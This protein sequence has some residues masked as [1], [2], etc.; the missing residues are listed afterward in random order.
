M[1]V[2]IALLS[3]SYCHSKR[4]ID[5]RKY[6]M[7]PDEYGGYYFAPLLSMAVRI[8]S[9]QDGGSVAAVSKWRENHVV[10]VSLFSC[11]VWRCKYSVT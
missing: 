11:G 5:D 4:L 10:V 7:S 9:V 3:E 8:V 6:V 1:R 2:S